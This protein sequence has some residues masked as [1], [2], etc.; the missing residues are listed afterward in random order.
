M[1]LIGGNL[2]NHH[3]KK[4]ITGND[5]TLM[6]MS[7]MRLNEHSISMFGRRLR[8]MREQAGMSQEELSQA[9]WDR[10]DA[11]KKGSQGHI[12]NLENSRG[13]KLPSV[14]VLRALAQILHTNTDYLLGLTDNYRPFGDLEDEVV[15]TIEDAAQRKI[16]QQVAEALA[17]ASLEDKEFVAGIVKRL[18]PQK[19]RNIGDE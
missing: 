1:I 16:V 15:V 4:Y 3:R 6:C 5:A 10:L 13:D 12:S 8:D 2:V 19:P 14:P 9:V 17:N 7:D 18:L 11:G